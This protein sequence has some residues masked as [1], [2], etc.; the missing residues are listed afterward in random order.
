MSKC[1][2]CSASIFVDYEIHDGESTR[3]DCA[4]CGRTLSHPTWYGVDQGEP[5]EQMA[6]ELQ[7]RQIEIRHA[8]AA[9]FEASQMKKRIAAAK[10]AR[11]DEVD[12]E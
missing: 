3:R 10:A 7:I 12:A 2:N 9:R 5:A 1:N 8:D 4:K 6:S 11:R